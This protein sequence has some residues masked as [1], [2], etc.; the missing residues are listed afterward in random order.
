MREKESLKTTRELLNSLI[1]NNNE[2]SLNKQQRFV[3]NTGD[4]AGVNV[5]VFV[6]SIL[7]PLFGE[8][9]GTKKLSW[10]ID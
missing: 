5:F 9:F 8:V 2:T 3:S 4:V 10:D 1:M 7:I 6:N